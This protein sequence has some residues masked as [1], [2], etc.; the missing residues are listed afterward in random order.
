MLSKNCCTA[1][2]PLAVGPFTGYAQPF[3]RT[4]RYLARFQECDGRFGMPRMRT[5]RSRGLAAP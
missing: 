1:A 2:M 4:S 5:A 3:C